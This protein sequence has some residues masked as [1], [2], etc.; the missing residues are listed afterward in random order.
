MK[1]KE[2]II[3]LTR[4]IRRYIPLLIFSLILAGVTVAL[5]LYFPILIGQAID[6]ILEKGNVDFD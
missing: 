3:K 5:T 1:N 6:L 2:T 4:Y